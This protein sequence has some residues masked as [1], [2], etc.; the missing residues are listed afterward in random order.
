MKY[1]FYGIFSLPWIWQ[2]WLYLSLL[3]CF[4]H[5]ACFRHRRG[6]TSTSR[7]RV[8]MT[9]ITHMTAATDEVDE[10]GKKKFVVRSREVLL[11]W[12]SDAIRDTCQSVYYQKAV[13]RLRIIGSHLFQRWTLVTTTKNIKLMFLFPFFTFFS[14][15]TDRVFFTIRLWPFLRPWRP[16][17]FWFWCHHS[18]I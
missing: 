6:S 11:F 1:T 7:L 4:E 17:T 5:P 15:S 18:I 10:V 14:A 3:G 13:C 8:H 9:H 16:L 12:N 2:P